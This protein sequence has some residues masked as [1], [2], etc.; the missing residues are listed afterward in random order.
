MSLETLYTELADGSKIYNIFY[1]EE[2]I[3]PPNHCFMACHRL[4]IPTNRYDEIKF[5]E[6]RDTGP[7]KRIK[8]WKQLKRHIENLDFHEEVNYNNA[9]EIINILDPYNKDN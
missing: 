5:S 1:D 2:W 7:H 3:E 6:V 4:L 9:M 8:G